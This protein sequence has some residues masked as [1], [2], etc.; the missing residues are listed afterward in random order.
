MRTLVLIA[1]SLVMAACSSKPATTEPVVYSQSEVADSIAIR[2]GRT[3]IVD[4][5]RIRFEAVESDSRC[6][7]DVVCVWQGDAVARFVIEQTGAPS[8]GVTLKLHTGLEPRSGTG[9]GFRVELLTLQPSPRASTPT[10][11]DD[12]VASIKVVPAS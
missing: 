8:S 2:V 4:G 5:T 3:I 12:H 1:A 11:A 7:V 9:H 6:P 10:K